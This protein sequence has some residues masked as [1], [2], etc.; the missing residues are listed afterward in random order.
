MVFRRN[1]IV[2]LLPRCQ[3]RTAFEVYSEPCPRSRME[4]FAKIV[5]G[6]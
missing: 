2:F 5:K 4:R 6:K 3:I 1:N